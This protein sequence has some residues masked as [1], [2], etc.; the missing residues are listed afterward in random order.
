MFYDRF[1]E[2]CREKGVKP[3]NACVEA[4]LSR[5][6]AAKWKSTKT[7][8]PSADALA[9]LSV[10]FKKPIEEILGIPQAE[11][12]VQHLNCGTSSVH[13]YKSVSPNG[14][15]WTIIGEEELSGTREVYKDGRVLIVVDEDGS[16]DT[17][18]LSK[19]IDTYKTTAPT[20][21][22]DRDVRAAFFDGIAPNLSDEERNAVWDEARR[23]MEFRIAEKQKGKK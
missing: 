10:Y 6:L 23:F 5:G 7:E 13:I 11:F 9:K 18:M 14:F 22:S 17:E 3:T 15:D 20:E 12:S 19:I 4:G 16:V 1:D 21:V 8:K 2:L